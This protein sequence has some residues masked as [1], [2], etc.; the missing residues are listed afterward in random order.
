MC[1]NRMHRYFWQCVICQYLK[2]YICKTLPGGM[3]MTAKQEIRI[4][5][6]EQKDLAAVAALEAEIFTDAWSLPLWKETLNSG[7]YDCQ[8]LEPDPSENSPE[9]AGLLFGYFC[10]QVILDEGEIHRI[11]I[12]PD[13]RQ[14]GYGQ[15]LLT[16]FLARAEQA[17]VKTFLLEVRAGNEPAIALYTKNG[18]A[19]IALRKSYYKNPKEDAFILQMKT[20]SSL[21][22]ITTA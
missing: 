20:R 4:R 9:S 18:F 17:G 16:D 19:R 10:G 6:M 21:R 22:N 12:R 13:L 2:I 3:I 1:Y 15:I 14:R 7:R 11:A 5:P 8:V